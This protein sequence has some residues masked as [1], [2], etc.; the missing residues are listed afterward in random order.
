MG[1]RAHILWISL[2]ASSSEAHCRGDE[3]EEGDID[4]VG[5]RPADVVWAGLDGTRVQWAISAGSRAAVG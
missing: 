3:L 4:F 5:V 1:R 2:T